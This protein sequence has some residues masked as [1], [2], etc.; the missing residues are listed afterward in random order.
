MAK[1]ILSPIL[2]RLVHKFGPQTLFVNFTSTS[3]Y[4]LFQAFMLLQFP[5]KLTSKT[6][7]NDE[8]LNFGLDFG[9]NLGTQ[10]CFCD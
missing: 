2:A 3:S 1:L 5:G 7:E 6:S 8:K 9:S 4:K 10:N